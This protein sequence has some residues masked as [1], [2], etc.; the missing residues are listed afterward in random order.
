MRATLMRKGERRGEERTGKEERNSEGRGPGEGHG[1]ERELMS[2]TEDSRSLKT[3]SASM[4]K[5]LFPTL[6][7]PVCSCQISILVRP[8][9]ISDCKV[10][11]VH[12]VTPGGCGWT[13]SSWKQ[14]LALAFP[15]F[16]VL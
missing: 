11:R 10:D 12:P 1:G 14:S 6:L 3:G 9:F 4:H 7:F 5:H 2:S 13:F 16:Q 8:F 15:I